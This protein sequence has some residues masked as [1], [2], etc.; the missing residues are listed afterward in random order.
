[1]LHMQVSTKTAMQGAVHILLNFLSLQNVKQAGIFKQ[2]VPCS[3]R[4][5][6]Q[7]LKV[8][9]HKGTDRY[10]PLIHSL[11]ATPDQHHQLWLQK[12]LQRFCDQLVAALQSLQMLP[13]TVRQPAVVS[14][15]RCASCL[16]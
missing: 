14:L 15:A 9:M 11:P 8:H 16:M 3:V 4:F 1:M 12:L 7:E 6:V 2:D 13:C 10:I 5:Q